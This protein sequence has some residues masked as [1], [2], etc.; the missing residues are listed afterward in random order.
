MYRS[1]KNDNARSSMIYSRTHGLA[2]FLTVRVFHP[3]CQR[4][5]VSSLRPRW[6]VRTTQISQ[7]SN[8]HAHMSRSWCSRFRVKASLVF[9]LGIAYPSDVG[10]ERPL[11]M[12][13]ERVWTD[14]PKPDPCPN[15][16]TLLCPA[17]ETIHGHGC[18]SKSKSSGYP[19]I[20]GYPC[21]YTLY[22]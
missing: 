10:L 11:R 8:C 12:A 17:H 22:T 14:M 21:V 19:D 16:P 7:C 15:P 3:C 18:R 5:S 1:D 9:S 13:M 20:H 2:S 6:Q 4:K